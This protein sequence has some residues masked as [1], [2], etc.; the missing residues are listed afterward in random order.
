MTFV[1]N[2]NDDL[3]TAVMSYCDSMRKS[4]EMIKALQ[5]NPTAVIKNVLQKKNVQ[6]E[7]PELF[8]AHVINDGESLPHEPL[9]A[10]IDRYIYVFRPSGL[11]EFKVVPGSPDGDDS[12]MRTPGGACSCCN[13]CVLVI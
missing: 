5:D 7:H 9:R 4:P 1:A 11:F 12:I 10:T 8:H 3:A 13:C 2:F 6:V